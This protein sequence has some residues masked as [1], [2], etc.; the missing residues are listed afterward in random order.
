MDLLYFARIRETIGCSSEKYNLPASVT[1]VG[2]LMECLREKGTNY[3]AAFGDE[4]LIRVA[5]N[6]T[7]VNFDHAI[8]DGDEV[9]F[10]PPMTGG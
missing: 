10:F 5:V 7:Y 6:Q 4:S 1:T 3:A 9:A 2:E 8:S